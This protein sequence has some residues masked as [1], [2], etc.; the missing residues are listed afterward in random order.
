MNKID[1]NFYHHGHACIFI[2]SAIYS[3]YFSQLRHVTVNMVRINSWFALLIVTSLTSDVTVSLQCPTS[4]GEWE[5]ASLA[6]QC[7]LPNSYHCL[8]D[9]KNVITE[10]CLA[11]VWIEGGIWISLIRCVESALENVGLHVSS[12]YFKCRIFFKNNYISLL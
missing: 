12:L 4:A 1:E 5:R 7:K 10:Q 2:I 3:V 8:K 11:K 6:L 9:E